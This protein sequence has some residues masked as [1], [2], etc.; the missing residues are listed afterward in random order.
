MRTDIKRG[1]EGGETGRVGLA[2]TV[3]AARD[4]WHF[5]C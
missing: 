5:L 4:F 2:V 3:S 1:E